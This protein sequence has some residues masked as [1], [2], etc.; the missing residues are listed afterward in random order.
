MSLSLPPSMIKVNKR[1]CRVCGTEVRSALSFREMMFGTRESFDYGMCT[2]CGSVQ[3]ME[4]PDDISRHYPPYYQAY[5]QKIP[6]LKLLP[7]FKRLFKALRIAKRYER[8]AA[9]PLKLLKPIKA[10][11]RSKIL[12]I[13]CGSGSLIC[14]LFNLGF[15]RVSGIDRFIPNAI[16]H[17]FGVKVQKKELAELPSKAYDVLIMQHVLEHIDDQVGQLNECHRLLRKGGV[18][19]IGIPV[20]NEA[21]DLYG[22]N[23]VQLDAPRHFILHTIDSMKRL[24]Q[25][26][27]FRIKQ[28]IYDSNEFQFLGSELY[29]RNIPLIMPDTREPFPMHTLFTDEQIEAYRQRAE[30][31]NRQK[32]GDSVQLYLHKS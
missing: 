16:D 12:D 2:D 4:V 18:L 21:W 10:G 30:T 5:A 23:W 26:T 25:S 14:S 8:D 6:E 1:P 17:G 7:P 11:P 28:V 24:A 19:L 15:E 27:G 31:L 32:R 9:W 22:S 29:Q 3:I 20:L 13:G